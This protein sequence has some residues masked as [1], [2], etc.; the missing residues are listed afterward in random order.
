MTLWT[1]DMWVLVLQLMQQKPVGVKPMFAPETVS[2]A[3]E[4]HI[5]PQE[6]HRRMFMLRQPE[7][8]SLRHLVE[9]LASHPIRL[10]REAE[11]VRQLR[12]CGN[13][14]S[15]FEGVSVVETFEKDF[16]PVHPDTPIT[17]VMLVMILDLYFR[18]VPSTMVADTPDVQE[19]A[20]MMHISPQE[21]ADVLEIYQ[22]CDPYLGH[23]ESLFDPLFPICYKTWHRFDYVADPESL[24]NL[25]AQL[26]AYFK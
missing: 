4:L 6:I 11:K 12:G 23:T 19:L 24:T 7:T 17:P 13:E 26:K 8:P 9:T 2:L 3:M 21:V 5:P 20:Q 16:R 18:L 10:N 1:E 15:F 25:A 14:Q 22:Y